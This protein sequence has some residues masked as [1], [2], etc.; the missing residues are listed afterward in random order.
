[1]YISFVNKILTYFL[2]YYVIL[3]L[4]VGTFGEHYE[5]NLAII[6]LSY[7]LPLFLTIVLFVV[8]IGFV[9][10]ELI[11]S[12]PIEKKTVFI[13]SVKMSLAILPMVHFTNWHINVITFLKAI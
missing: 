9:I 4:L 8:A 11:K 13:A 1:M 7:G 5:D 3:I 6:L 10:Y 12:E 2:I